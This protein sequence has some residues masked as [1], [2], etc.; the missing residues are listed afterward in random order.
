MLLG[1]E[2]SAE[3]SLGAE[4]TAGRLLSRGDEELARTLAA[5]AARPEDRS[6]LLWLLIRG[7]HLMSHRRQCE[8]VLHTVRGFA[9]LPTTEMAEVFM[10]VAPRVRAARRGWKHAKPQ[11]V[12]LGGASSSSSSSKKPAASTLEEDGDEGCVPAFVG[13]RGRREADPATVE[14]LDAIEVALRRLK[15][16]ERCRLYRRLDKGV[17]EGL[18]PSVFASMLAELPREEV[19][20][21]EDWLVDEGGISKASVR[22][23]FSVLLQASAAKDAVCSVGGRLADRADAVWAGLSEDFRNG[24]DNR[25]WRDWLQGELNSPRESLAGESTFSHGP[26]SRLTVV[27]KAALTARRL[28]AESER[29][30][31]AEAAPARAAGGYLNGDDQQLKAA[32]PPRR[33]SCQLHCPPSTFLWKD[34]PCAAVQPTPSGET[35]AAGGP[36]ASLGVQFGL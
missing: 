22:Q 18:T 9:A 4:E 15:R 25:V 35:A 10:A 12:Y 8:L 34:A 7:F 2:G 11:Q 3:V 30:R 14:M 36:R 27:S 28:A 24:D 19:R 23:L 17:S 26:A 5:A 20:A 16:S 13:I 1:P 29:R 6:T 33:A 21:L 31:Q 32:S